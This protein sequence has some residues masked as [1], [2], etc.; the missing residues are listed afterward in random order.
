M[1]VALSCVHIYKNASATTYVLSIEGG[2]GAV[3]TQWG[4]HRIGTTEGN[5]LCR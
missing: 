1:V 5:G 3:P 4:T 2:S